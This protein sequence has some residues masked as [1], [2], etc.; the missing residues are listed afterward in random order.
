MHLELIFVNKRPIH[1]NSWKPPYPYSL[2]WR[3][4]EN[5]RDD[6]PKVSQM[7][8]LPTYI[9]CCVGVEGSIQIPCR[10]SAIFNICDKRMILLLSSIYLSKWWTIKTLLLRVVTINLLFLIYTFPTSSDLRHRNSDIQVYSLSIISLRHLGLRHSASQI[11]SIGSTHVCNCGSSLTL[12]VFICHTYIDIDQEIA[13]MGKVDVFNVVIWNAMRSFNAI[14][15]NTKSLLVQANDGVSYRQVYIDDM[16]A[17]DWR[18]LFGD[19]TG[20]S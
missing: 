18:G 10:K 15:I 20:S 9:S 16:F 8:V 3:I 11:G 4:I 12:G 13:I 6:M 5:K 7:E 1:Q 2:H 14:N 17:F 19:V